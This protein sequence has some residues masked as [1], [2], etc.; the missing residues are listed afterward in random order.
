MLAITFGTAVEI[1]EKV[2]GNSLGKA[3]FWVRMTSATCWLLSLG[4]M[5][6]AVVARW[7]R[8]GDEVTKQIFANFLL[9]GLIFLVFAFLVSF[10][11]FVL[12]WR[13]RN[14]Q[15]QQLANQMDQWIHKQI[16]EIENASSDDKTSQSE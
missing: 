7:P 9:A 13:A 12:F 6:F 16:E 1:R 8:P 11:D 4:L 5:S 14:V 15:R 3:H 10:V 2:A